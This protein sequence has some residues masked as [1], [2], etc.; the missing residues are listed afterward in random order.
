MTAAIMAFLLL[1]VT[2]TQSLLPAMVW[3][4]SAKWPCLLGVVLYYALNQSR[5]M[6]VTVAILA[7]TIQDSLSLIPLGYSALCF[8][9]TGLIL[10]QIRE[11]LFRDSLLTVASVGAVAA[12]LNTFVLYL[13]L[14]VGDALADMP[15]GWVALKVCGSALLGGLSAP[16]IWVTAHSLDR[17]VGIVHSDRF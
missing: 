6:V 11:V 13:M 14:S 17:H 3:L 7:G 10:V 9:V 12:G 8:T 16:V 2:L 15:A 5:G 4:G 1:A